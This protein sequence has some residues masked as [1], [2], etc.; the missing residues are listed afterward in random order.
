VYPTE[1]ECGGFVIIDREF[2]NGDVVRMLFEENQKIKV[3]DYP[4]GGQ[5]VER[6]PLVYTLKIKEKR[7]AHPYIP[8]DASQH[9]PD[10]RFTQFDIYPGSPWNYALAA[11][12]EHIEKEA[13]VIKHRPGLRPFESGNSPLEIKLPVKRVP[14]WDYIGLPKNKVL[15]WPHEKEQQPD[16]Y[17]FTP[18][19]PKDFD[20]ASEVEYVRFVP[21]GST[22]IRMTILPR[23]GKN[24]P[25]QT[26]L[27]GSCPEWDEL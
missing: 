12:A 5:F 6:G 14:G 9:C 22:C 19:L 21:Y 15:Q 20:C 27:A 24:N 8:W 17:L 16:V 26:V 25:N 10:S 23:C 4:A 1:T 7:I 13:N 11:D 3:V 2:K 18:D